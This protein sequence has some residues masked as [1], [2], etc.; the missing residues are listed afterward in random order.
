[1]ALEESLY[2]QVVMILRK[3]M[4]QKKKNEKA[5]IG[6]FSKRQSARSKHWFDFYIEWVEDIF[7]SR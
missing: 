4:V 3:R 6:T 2:L 7:I 1:M 5:K